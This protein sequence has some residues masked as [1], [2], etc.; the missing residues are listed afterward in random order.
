M[1]LRGQTQSQLQYYNS[2][3]RPLRDMC[4]SNYQWISRYHRCCIGELQGVAGQ[5]GVYKRNV[6][7]L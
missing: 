5:A 6:H 3:F 4:Q 7:V 1:Q 2:A